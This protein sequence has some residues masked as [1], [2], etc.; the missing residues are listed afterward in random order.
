[1]KSSLGTRQVT[2]TQI[3]VPAPAGWSIA[4]PVGSVADRTLTIAPNAAITFSGQGYTF[5]YTLTPACTAPTTVQPLNLTSTFS[6][7]SATGIAGATFS[8]G[9]TRSNENS[10]AGSVQ[11]NSLVWNETYSLTESSVRGNLTYQV[12][13]NGCSGWNIQVSAS[14]FQYT[15]PNNG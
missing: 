10:L 2:L 7:D 12:V 15:G 6:F 9:V 5:S 11:D 3:T 4:G 1:G 13:A 14:P 8:Q